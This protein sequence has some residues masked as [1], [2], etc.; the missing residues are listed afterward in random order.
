MATVLRRVLRL[1]K[2]FGLGLVVVLLLYLTVALIFSLIIIDQELNDE[3]EIE[4]WLHSNGVHVD[5]VVPAQNDTF[6]WYAVVAPSHTRSGSTDFSWLAFGWGDRGFY[7]NTPEWKD[8]RFSTA[9]KA[10]LGLG[11][12][13]MHT[14]YH[15]QMTVSERT[16]RFMISRA[17]YLTLCTFLKSGFETTEDGAFQP[18]GL[19][20][21]YGQHDAFYAGNG[22]YSLFKTCNSWTNNALKS[23]G[24]P[25]CLWTPFEGGLMR[26]GRKHGLTPGSI[27]AQGSFSYLESRAVCGEVP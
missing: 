26:L 8:L 23:A 19:H 15:A 27:N 20:A 12:S 25:H 18:I 22:R 16:H 1:T 21:R 7:L 2:K 3:P 6:D 24:L 10:T 13:A 4:I 9:F 17:N 14:T 5:V 11:K